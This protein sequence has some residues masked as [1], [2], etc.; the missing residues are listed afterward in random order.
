MKFLSLKHFCRFPIPITPPKLTI[1]FKSY[2]LFICN[3]K[4]CKQALQRSAFHYI[5]QNWAKF[6]QGVSYKGVSGVKLPIYALYRHLL[7]M[8]APNKTRDPC[9]TVL[10]WTTVLV[11][12]SIE[13]FKQKTRKNIENIFILYIPIF[14]NILKNS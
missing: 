4:R 13:N 8:I 10:T 14:D 7:S 11:S 1:K 3:S 12:F 2:M 6:N 9:A 5:L